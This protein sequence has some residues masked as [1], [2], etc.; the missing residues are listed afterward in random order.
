MGHGIYKQNFEVFLDILVTSIYFDFC[1]NLYHYNLKDSI[2]NLVI[3]TFLSFFFVL[4]FLPANALNVTTPTP[5]KKFDLQASLAKP[6][7]YKPHTGKLKPISSYQ[8]EVRPT[9]SHAKVKN[10]KV[11]VKSVKVASR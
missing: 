3:T 8:E 11:D 6:L 5:R 9:M 10:H 2:S 1:W 4:R 7:S